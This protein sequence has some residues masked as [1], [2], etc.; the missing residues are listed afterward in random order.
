MLRCIMQLLL[1]LL[2]LLALEI[3]KAKS[4][5]KLPMVAT[6]RFSLMLVDLRQ[7]YYNTI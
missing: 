4:N 6:H 7:M 5:S 3:E 2:L 1:V